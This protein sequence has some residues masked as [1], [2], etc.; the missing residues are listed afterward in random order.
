MSKVCDVCG[1]GAQVGN[2]RSHAMNA[3]KRKFYPNLHSI[4][5]EIGGNVKKIKICSS[6]LK[7]NKVKKVV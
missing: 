5:A 2:H 4:K 3:T 7:A 6:C 1:K